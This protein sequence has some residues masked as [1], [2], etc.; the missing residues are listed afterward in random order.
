MPEVVSLWDTTDWAAL[1][2]VFGQTWRKGT[3]VA[4][5][6]SLQ[7]VEKLGAGD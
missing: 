2:K 7:H 5:L 6:P 3:L 1:K 4:P